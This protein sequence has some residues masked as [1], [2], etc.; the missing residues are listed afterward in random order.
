M[1]TWPWH[2]AWSTHPGDWGAWPGPQLQRPHWDT[3]GLHVSVHSMNG[4][5]SNRHSHAQTGRPHA[6]PGIRSACSEPAT[7]TGWLRAAPALPGGPCL[8]LQPPALSEALL[9]VQLGAH[10]QGLP[11]TLPSAQCRARLGG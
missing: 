5:R 9:G 2:L 7:L 1:E 11:S 4:H 6:A 10:V 3:R 8:T